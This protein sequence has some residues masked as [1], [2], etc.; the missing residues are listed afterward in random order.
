MPE[1]RMSEIMGDRRT[2]HYLRINDQPRVICLSGLYLRIG[3]KQA[4][5]RLPGNLRYLQRMGQAGPV[6]IAGTCAEY[7]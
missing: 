3:T 6:I 7:L 5:G 2:F 4:F 1:R